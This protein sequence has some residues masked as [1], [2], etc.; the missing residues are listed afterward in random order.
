MNKEDLAANTTVWA[1]MGNYGYREA[2][3]E[4]PGCIRK[5]VPLIFFRNGKRVGF[6][7]RSP[8][9]CFPRDPTLNGSD[10]PMLRP[11]EMAA[12]TNNQNY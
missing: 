5:F 1:S 11:Q 9:Q 6:G 3:V 4:F 8:D 10:K 12:Q 7:K 2:V